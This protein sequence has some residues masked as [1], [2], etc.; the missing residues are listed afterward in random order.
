ML[1][2]IFFLCPSCHKEDLYKDY[3]RDVLVCSNCNTLYSIVNN[4]PRLLDGVE[5]YTKSFGFEWNIFQKTQLDSYTSLPISQSRIF[6]I[7]GWNETDNLTCKNILEAG[8]GAGRFTEI[9]LKTGANLYSFDYSDAVDANYRNNQGDD[10]LVLFQADINNIPFKND[11]FDYV[12]C[13]GVLQHTPDP[14]KAFFN[15]SDKV[16]SGGYIYIDIYSRTLM[17]YFHWKY[18][19]RPFT[20]RMNHNKLFQLIKRVTPILV[21]VVIILK[22]IFGRRLGARVLPIVEYSDMNLNKNI[23]IEW[24]ILDTFD[25]YSPEY[26]NPQSLLTVR[27]WFNEYGFKDI[28]VQYGDNGIVARAMK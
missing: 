1:N 4:V 14:K 23:N 13:I 6:N 25:M 27:K 28:V 7:T 5:N 21:P 20:K 18:I 26:D 3:D 12:F 16:S 8:S 15:L 24:A 2:S 11:C 9:L 10:H 22:K 19:L 17:S